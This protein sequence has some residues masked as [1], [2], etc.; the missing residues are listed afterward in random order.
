M[1]RQKHFL[2]KNR[3]VV[4]I[5]MVIIL[6]VGVTFLQQ[7]MKIRELEYERDYIETEIE[8]LNAD[9]TDLESKIEETKGLNYVEQVA[10]EKL[11]MVRSDEIVYIIDDETPQ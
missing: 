11:K 9:I 8:S 3:I 10:R 4:L 6:Y 2:K 5:S 7:E 1:G